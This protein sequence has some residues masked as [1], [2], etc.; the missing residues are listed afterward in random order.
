MGGWSEDLLA[1]LATTPWQ[2]QSM[3]PPVREQMP[4][5][6]RLG[7]LLAVVALHVLLTI[8]FLRL[9]EPEP[10]PAVELVTL[11]DF[12]Q[13][14]PPVPEPAPVPNETITIRMPPPRTQPRVVERAPRPAPPRPAPRRE[15]DLPMQVVDGPPRELQLYNP[16]GSV[17][18]PADML[19]RLDEQFGDKRVFSYQIPNMDDAKKYFERNPALVYESTRFEQ[20]W[21]PDA[22]ALTAMLTK[23]AEATTRE[24]KVKVP[25]T[26]GSYMVCKVSILA[27]GGGCGVLTNGAD[28]N[29]PQDDPNTLN[30]EEERQCA[31]WWQQII[32]ARTQDAWRATR[33]LYERE[34]RKPR[35][36]A[37]LG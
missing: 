20:Y 27:L 16:D 29:G 36:R 12:I 33:K 3:R 2:P 37:G 14:P 7:L 30:E 25:G 21:T 28:W 9:L 17:R 34:C 8:A 13:E 31:A 4:F 6:L 18:V 10:E 5:R 35:Q 22:D 11:I 15:I 32:D 24:I 26:N 1:G 23:F 19:D